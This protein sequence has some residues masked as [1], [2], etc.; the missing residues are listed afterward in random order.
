MNSSSHLAIF[1]FLTAWAFSGEA[2]AMFVFIIIRSW[3]CAI[4]TRA[5]LSFLLAERVP[6]GLLQRISIFRA[7]VER[8]ESRTSGVLVPGAV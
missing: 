3:D 6:T 4:S 8:S 7:R 5:G 2:R 1:G